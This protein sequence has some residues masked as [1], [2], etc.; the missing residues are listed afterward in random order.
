VLALA[1]ELARSNEVSST[2]ELAKHLT[3]AA[4]ADLRSRL[5]EWL[6]RW[7]KRGELESWAE[8]QGELGDYRK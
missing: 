3:P 4:V 7:R 2:V 8:V 1:D 5:N 6:Q